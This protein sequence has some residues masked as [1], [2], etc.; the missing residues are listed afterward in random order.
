V[1]IEETGE[2]WEVDDLWRARSIGGDRSVIGVDTSRG[3][4]LV[5]AF[6]A[7]PRLDHELSFIAEDGA[8]PA[9]RIDLVIV[10]QRVMVSR[11][12]R[13][14][15]APQRKSDAVTSGATNMIDGEIVCGTAWQAADGEL[16]IRRVAWDEEGF[17]TCL[18]AS[19]RVRFTGCER[20]VAD[21][22]VSDLTFDVQLPGP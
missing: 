16:L 1:R 11:Q 2:V 14:R 7:P 22:P 9:A 20:L 21:E 19:L 4:S 5:I 18:D 12:P 15:A 13:R 17:V 3:Y 6:E 10:A 8:L